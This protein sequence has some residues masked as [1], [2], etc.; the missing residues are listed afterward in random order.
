MDYLSEQIIPGPELRA[1]REENN[2]TINR[3]AALC[4]VT[5][6]TWGRWEANG[7]PSRV[8]IL[9]EQ[10]EPQP[11]KPKKTSISRSAGRPRLSPEEAAERYV[12]IRAARLKAVDAAKMAETANW[13]VNILL[14]KGE[15]NP[16]PMVKSGDGFVKV[17]LSTIELRAMY[18][19]LAKRAKAGEVEYARAAQLMRETIE[20]WAELGGN[21]NSLK[22]I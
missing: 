22:R 21:Q 10:I 7:A 17:L 19:N 4:G 20:S 5:W 2:L 9:L 15:Y 18:D 12:A 8:R 14:D 3:C 1:W 16:M 6:A 11:H 13:R